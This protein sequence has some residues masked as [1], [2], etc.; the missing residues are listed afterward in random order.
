MSDKQLQKEL[1]AFVAGLLKKAKCD[2]AGNCLTM[3]GLIRNYLAIVYRMERMECMVTSTMVQQ[4]KKK[5][6]HYYLLRVKDGIIID[7]TA[8]QFKFPDGKQMPLV[9]IGEK[10]NFYL[11]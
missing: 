5:I 2:H 4:G 6:N 1:T 8:S 9:Y 10:P 11:F 7:C 3:S